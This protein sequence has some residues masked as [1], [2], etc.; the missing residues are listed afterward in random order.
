MIHYERTSYCAL[1]DGL[2]DTHTIPS[3]N[4]FVAPPSNPVALHISK[5][6]PNYGSDLENRLI[7]KKKCHFSYQQSP[8]L[9]TPVQSKL[10]HV[11]EYTTSIH[12]VVFSATRG[13]KHTVWHQITLCK[14]ERDGSK[15]CRTKKRI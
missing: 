14:M 13:M 10:I 4:R 3:F 8:L 11:N 12:D 7:K 9:D 2:I 1:V 15:G 6:F 5:V